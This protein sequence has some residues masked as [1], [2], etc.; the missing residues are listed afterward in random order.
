MEKLPTPNRPMTQKQ[1]PDSQTQSQSGRRQQQGGDPAGE[2]ADDR[3]PR[4]PDRSDLDDTKD[5]AEPGAPRNSRHQVSR[6]DPDP[7]PD[8]HFDQNV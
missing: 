6:V 8:E 4:M 1:S 7:S 3:S 2:R 5:A